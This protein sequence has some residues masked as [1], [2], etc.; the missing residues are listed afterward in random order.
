M[1]GK[2]EGAEAERLESLSIERRRLIGQA[3][4][5]GIWLRQTLPWI[6]VMADPDY[7]Q[8]QGNYTQKG[9][10]HKQGGGDYNQSPALQGRFDLVNPE[11]PSGVRHP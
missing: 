5:D 3:I 10:D 2:L 8:G 4:I 11:N 9:G 1:A 7:N 6:H